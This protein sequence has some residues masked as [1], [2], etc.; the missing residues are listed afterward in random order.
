MTERLNHHLKQGGSKGE[1][2]LL[3]TPS[4]T[5]CPPSP[6]V[7]SV[8]VQILQDTVSPQGPEARGEV[9]QAHEG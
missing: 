5:A 1:E 3:P 8:G 9:R 4:P 2:A 6:W 7:P